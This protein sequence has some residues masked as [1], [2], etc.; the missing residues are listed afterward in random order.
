MVKSN[1][2]SVPSTTN[3][4]FLNDFKVVPDKDLPPI[5]IPSLTPVQAEKVEAI[6]TLFNQRLDKQDEVTIRER[7]QKKEVD[8]QLKN[9]KEK[10]QELSN[11]LKQHQDSCQ[12]LQDSFSTC[13]IRSVDEEVCVK[14][15]KEEKHKLKTI[16]DH[17]QK[18]NETKT[19]RI[20]ELEY[21][22]LSLKGKVGGSKV[23]CAGIRCRDGSRNWKSEY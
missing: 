10:N 20:V 12:E 23:R 17:W 6:V 11:Q 2:P 14:V 13:K 9:M 22:V 19:A 21:E 15:P 16:C 1:S 7:L 18:K 3:K 4:Q 8:K 5:V